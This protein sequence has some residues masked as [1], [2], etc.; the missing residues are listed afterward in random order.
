MCHWSCFVT[1]AIEAAHLDFLP[2]Q[3]L[4]HLPV[5][6]KLGRAQ[7][8]FLSCISTPDWFVPAR[9]EYL[10]SCDVFI[11]LRVAAASAASLFIWRGSLSPPALAA[12]A[13]A[14]ATRIEA[15]MPVLTSHV[16]ELAETPRFWA[17]MDAPE[18]DTASAAAS[19]YVVR[20]ESPSGAQPS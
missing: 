3:H 2:R 16:A 5:F 19:S 15:A 18:E 13:A 20:D 12:A 11:L 17:A 7:P 9:P 6:N 14:I 8:S 10:D 4:D 1:S